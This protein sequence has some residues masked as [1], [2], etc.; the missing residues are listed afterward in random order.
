MRSGTKKFEDTKRVTGS[1]KR[2]HNGQAKKDKQRSTKHY[3]E[4]PRSSNPNPP[5]RGEGGGEVNS[6]VRR[7]D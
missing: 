3:T 4:Q 2:Q 5:N 6:G 1:R 7:K